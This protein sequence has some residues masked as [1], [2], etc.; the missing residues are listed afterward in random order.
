MGGAFGIVFLLE[1]LAGREQLTIARPAEPA[2]VHPVVEAQRAD[3][4][5]EQEALGWTA[6]EEAQ[7]PS[8]AMTIIGAPLRE[9]EE[10]EPAAEAEAAEEPPEVPPAEEEEPEEPALPPAAETAAEVEPDGRRRWWRRGP[11]AEGA[12][13]MP[14]QRHHVR[15]LPADEQPEATDPWEQGFDSPPASEAKKIDEPDEDT[16]EALEEPVRRRFRRR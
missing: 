15:V 1:W 4:T 9:A 12:D 8:D 3:D 11:S 16:D 5:E 2:P 14:E 13:P 7:E 6:F 10:P